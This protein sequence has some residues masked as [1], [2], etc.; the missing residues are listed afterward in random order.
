MWS[1][2]FG[3]SS[4][5]FGYKV[6][7]KWRHFAETERDALAFAVAE[8]RN[9]IGRRNDVGD[10]DKHAVDWA[11]SLLGKAV[12]TLLYD[13]DYAGTIEAEDITAA[14]LHVPPDVIDQDAHVFAAV[15]RLPVWRALVV[16]LAK[17]TRKRRKSA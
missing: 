15:H 16:V 7:E 4:A 5:G 1:T 10:W 8:L 9:G 12:E 3:G 13:P 2:A 17:N 14:L 6:G 11:E